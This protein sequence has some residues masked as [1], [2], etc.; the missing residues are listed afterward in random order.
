VNAAASSSPGVTRYITKLEVGYALHELTFA[1]LFLLV[2]LIALRRRR[3]WAWWAAWAVMIADI[4][5]TVTFGRHDA[6]ILARGPVA[7]IAVPVFLLLCAPAVLGRRTSVAGPEP[8]A[9]AASLAG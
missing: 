1:V 7:D 6:T 2:V 5:Y 3:A 4:G 9:A 8:A